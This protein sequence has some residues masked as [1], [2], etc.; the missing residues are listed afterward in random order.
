[1]IQDTSL[2]A[3]FGEKKNH[4]N[5]KI[6]ITN[7]LSVYGT[8]TNK[9]ISRIAKLETSSVSGRVNDLRKEGLVAFCEKRIC[10]I[11]GKRVNAWRLIQ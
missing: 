11:S 4:N 7:L 1:M 3:Y 9:E 6:F 10:S 2:D 5:Q 8:L